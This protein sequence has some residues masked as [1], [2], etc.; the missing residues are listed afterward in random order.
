MLLFQRARSAQLK[1]VSEGTANLMCCGVRR[2]LFSVL[3]LLALTS[4]GTAQTSDELFDSSVLH[5]LRLYIH[6]HDWV[7][8]RAHYLKNTHYPAELYWRGVWVADIAVRSRG[9]GSRSGLKPGLTVE[10]N[11]YLPGQRFLG[12]TALVLDNSLQD[13]SFLR[14]R[15]SLLLFRRMGIAAPRQA[16]ARLYIN[17]AYAGLY[18][19]VESVDEQFLQYHFR[20]KS[21]YLYEYRW[22]EPSYQFEYLGQNAEL[23]SPARFRPETRVDDFDPATLE[24]MVHA[25]NATSEEDFLGE[26]SQFLD[27]KLFMKQVAVENFLAEPDG[28]L[29]LWGMNN[30]YLY[31]FADTVRFQCIPWDKD[32]TLAGSWHSIWFNTGS[33]VLI[34]RALSHPVL[35][36]AYLDALQQT[37][38]EAGGA[39]G[40]LEQELD[41]GYT[42]ILLAAY[43]DSRKP[44]DNLQ[45]EAAVAA[46]R[47]FIQSRR[48]RV[49]EQIAAARE[50]VGG[51]Q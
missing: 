2:V 12:L 39:G 26:V 6:P 40:W 24:R 47:E 5:D 29:G 48:D 23:Y 4:P 32:M 46:T 9:Y 28:I 42:Q 33:N 13:P 43:E 50:S 49:L 20:E 41:R 14:E 3:L 31:R 10:F 8:L 22:S 17:D 1:I 34:K 18:S 36:D 45:F 27:L 11:R 15:L 16:Y 19:M 25:I 30:F 7:Q 44:Q 21:G 37:T 38:E 51:R 35:Y